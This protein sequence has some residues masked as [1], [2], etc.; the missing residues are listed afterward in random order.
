M[1]YLK[2]RHAQLILACFLISSLLF[3]KFPG[4]DLGISTIFF[5]K[6]FYLAGQ[7]KSWIQDSVRYFLCLSVV[8]VIGL[9]FYN[10]YSKRN[11]FGIDGKKV[12]YLLLVLVLGAGMIVNGVLKEDFGR[13]R[14]RDIVEFGGSKIFTPAFVVSH[15]CDS[16]CSFSSGDG[17]GAFFALA[18]ALALSRRRAVLLSAF[19]F[20]A[21][22]S[23][24][25]VAS[26]AHFLSDCVVSFFIMLIVA[27]VLYYYLVLTARERVPGVGL[28]RLYV[29]G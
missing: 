18:L 20:G 14:P 8:S 21:F 28:E 10:R 6:G 26:G 4:I 23:Y 22:V 12:A 5:D 11:L 1:S 9:Y 24:S 19:A 27:D 15:E 25:R 29:A 7:W 13:A 2:L 3:V 16:N 17:A